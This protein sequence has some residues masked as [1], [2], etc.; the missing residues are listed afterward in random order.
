M[1]YLDHKRERLYH[2]HTRQRP[3]RLAPQ[4]HVACF[5][6]SLSHRKT[7]VCLTSAPLTI[8][9]LT[10][11]TALA[12]IPSPPGAPNWQSIYGRQP[13]NFILGTQSGATEAVTPTPCQTSFARWCLGAAPANPSGTC[14]H[15]APCTTNPHAPLPCLPSPTYPYP[16]QTAGPCCA[17]LSVYSQACTYRT[18]AG[19]QMTL[20]SDPDSYV[21]RCAQ[22]A[23]A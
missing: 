21:P 20:F 8:T 7:Q 23:P 5:T 2:H 9:C 17:G 14:P 10:L 12:G 13:V 1:E 4:T 6:L 19:Q 18:H 22:T 3:E 16:G 11:S 15:N